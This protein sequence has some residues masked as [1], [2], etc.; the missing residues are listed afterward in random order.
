MIVLA[1]S[2]KAII[3]RVTDYVDSFSGVGVG[4]DIFPYTTEEIQREILSTRVKLT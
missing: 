3:D 1:R 4:V 2:G